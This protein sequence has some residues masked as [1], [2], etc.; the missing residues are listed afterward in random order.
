[1]CRTPANWF[2]R[3]IV[4][5]AFVLAITVPSSPQARGGGGGG[6][7]GGGHGRGGHGVFHGSAFGRGAFAHSRNFG[8][9]GFRVTPF[10]S[11]VFP[12]ASGGIVPPFSGRPIVPPFHAAPVVG[13]GFF[14]FP[15]VWHWSSGAWFP[16]FGGLPFGAVGL[17]VSSGIVPPF[18]AGA[19]VP[20]FQA[21]P[22]VETGFA[23]LPEVWHRGGGSWHRDPVG[24]SPQ[25]WHRDKDGNWH[26]EFAHGSK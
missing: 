5:I 10:R 20:P 1:M 2:D 6:H 14:S 8:F 4:T 7:G 19:I 17:P 13:A 23:R 24:P 25:I 11:A 15:E 9:H 16:G 12:F 18:S 22:V 26:Q 3:V 21:T